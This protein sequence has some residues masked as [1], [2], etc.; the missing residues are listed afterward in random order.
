MNSVSFIVPA[1]NE[2][3]SLPNLWP[4][5]RPVVQRYSDWELIIVS[6]GSTDGTNAFVSD[7]SRQEPRIKLIAFPANRGK[8]AALM[9]GFKAV[10]GEYVAML[11]AD[12]QDEPEEIPKMLDLLEKTPADMVGGWKQNRQDP[13]VKLISSKVFN[14]LANKIMKTKFHDLNCGLKVYRRA[15]VE[16]LD[17]YG[18]LY[19]FIPILAVARGFRA[20]EMPVV[21]HARKWGKSKYGLRLN[22][23][24]DLV[25]LMMLTRYRFRPLHFFGRW[26]GLLILVGVIIM[27][28]LTVEHFRGLAIG[29]R[30]LLIFGMLFILTGLQM[31][32]TGLLADIV[33]NRQTRI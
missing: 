18:D 10:Q 1:W 33:I 31:I 13:V 9:A 2:A 32:F 17:L 15:V 24:F 14:W 4:R 22:G 16:S 29:D 26:G 3:E 5:L 21:H 11:D 12:L 8:S 30:P 20:I 23:I 25:S 27:I 28:Y 7:L 19:R 6:D